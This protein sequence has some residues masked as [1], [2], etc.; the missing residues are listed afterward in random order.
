MRTYEYSLASFSVLV[1]ISY[2][3]LLCIELLGVYSTPTLQVLPTLTSNSFGLKEL[4]VY[5]I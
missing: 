3:S 2:C 5:I 1:A 4:L